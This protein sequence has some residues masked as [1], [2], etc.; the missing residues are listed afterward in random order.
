MVAACAL[1]VHLFSE[2]DEFQVKV[3]ESSAEV[4]RWANEMNFFQFSSDVTDVSELV[5]SYGLLEHSR[6]VKH[7]KKGQHIR[8]PLKMSVPQQLVAVFMLGIDCQSMLQPSWFGFEIMSTNFVKCALA[9][10]AAV[11]VSKRP[12]VKDTLSCLGFQLDDFATGETIANLWNSLGDWNAIF[13][14]A[15]F[16]SQ[17]HIKT[18]QLD[19]GLRLLTGNGGLQLLEIDKKLKRAI[20]DN[21]RGDEKT[22]AVPPIACINRGNSDLCDGIVTFFANE[23]GFNASPKKISI[24]IQV[25]DYHEKSTVDATGMNFHVAKHNNEALNG[26]FGETRLFC[27][28][29]TKN[30]LIARQPVARKHEY[31]P[32]IVENGC[33][34]TGLL[35]ELKLQRNEKLQ[36]AKCAFLC[37]KNGNIVQECVEEGHQDSSRKRKASM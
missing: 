29:S 19:A 12:S 11:S 2:Q 36:V 33:L 26:V 16:R 22:G 35:Q 10:S 13:A 27:V 23:R 15:V 25:K 5:K 24:M 20:V 21:L 4:A 32:F 37:D 14:S 18:Q 1:A 17:Y 34:L 8:P 28:A 9:A 31:L 3:P 30:A 7:H 6:A